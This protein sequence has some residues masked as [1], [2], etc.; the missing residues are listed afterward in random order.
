[1]H[2]AASPWSDIPVFGTSKIWNG[3]FLGKFWTDGLNAKFE[4]NGIA[5]ELGPS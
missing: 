5:Q 1:L 4:R 2:G 3:T